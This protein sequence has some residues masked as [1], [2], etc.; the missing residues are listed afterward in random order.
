MRELGPIIGR[1]TSILTV[2]LCLFHLF[3]GVF[4][5]LPGFE[6]RAVHVAL[7]L[8]LV[9][10]L[11]PA[12]KAGGRKTSVPFWDWLF[13]ALIM[14]SCGWIFLNWQ[15]FQP[16]LRIPLN[17]VLLF[18][19]LVTVAIVF[20]AARRRIGWVFS[21]LAA[22]ALVYTVW[23]HYIP[24]TWGHPTLKLTFFMEYLFFSSQGIWGPITGI[25][26][27]YLASILI[28]GSI[29]A[30]TGGGQTFFDLSM[31][32]A[33]RLRGGPAKVA[34]IASAAFGCISGSGAANVA[35]TGNFTI[36]MMKQQGY[37]PEFAAAVE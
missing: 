34:V 33:G 32:L 22:V 16:F 10:T 24:G 5:T 2:S 13:V 1:I 21:L 12:S 17:N 26:A 36:P 27:T 25:S 28:F 19:A 37:D 14:A 20:E 15:Q 3:T 31:I 29:L 7:V 9:L 23:G 35:T 6:Q 8:F 11:Y 18:M 30:S 4:G